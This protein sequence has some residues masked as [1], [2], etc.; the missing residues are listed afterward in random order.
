MKKTKIWAM[1]IALCMLVLPSLAMGEV[2][3][4]PQVAALEDITQT[5]DNGY[6]S[7]P[8]VSGLATPELEALVNQIIM[9]KAD[10]KTHLDTLTILQESVKVS[11]QAFLHDNILSVAFDLSGRTKPGRDGQKYVTV[12]LDL[13]TGEGI[14]AADLFADIDGAKAAMEAI[15]EEKVLPGMSGYMENSDLIPVPVDTFF[16]D[17]QGITFY[18]A[19]DQF[20]FVSGYAGGAS[21]FYYELQDSLNVLEGSILYRLGAMATY[22]PEQMKESIV[23]TVTAGTLPG[24][25]LTLGDDLAKALDT[26]RLLCEPDFYPGGRFF[27]TEAPEMRDVWIMTDHLTEEYTGKVLGIR[28]DR[29]DLYGIQTG[30]TTKAQWQDILGQPDSTVSLDDYTAEDYYLTGGTSDYYN[31]GEHQLRLHGDEDGVLQSVQ[32]LQ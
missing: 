3:P 9:E 27:L 26:Y 24:I 32:V 28:A 13:I 20:S 8:K 1:L 31:Y 11:Y 2:I 30:I 5:T 15:L 7:Y 17:Q 21:F 6:V 25:A 10:I 23:K 14:T 18:Y 22:T 4:K 29:M 16:F 19:L 12:N